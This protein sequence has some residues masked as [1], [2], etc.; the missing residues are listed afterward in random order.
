MNNSVLT[1]VIAT[2]NRNQWIERIT[3]YYSNIR[4]SHKIF[5][6][7]S[8]DENKYTTNKQIVS[9]HSKEL[10]MTH[11]YL[12]NTSNNLAIA[13]IIDQIETEYTIVTGDDDYLVP[14]TLTHCIEFLEKNNDYV[15]VAGKVFSPYVYSTSDST[16]GVE[17]IIDSTNDVVRTI[18]DDSA[19]QRLI[20][21]FSPWDTS[22][23]S[24]QR[25]SMIKTV[26][27]NLKKLDLESH[28][29]TFD[30]A[31]WAINGMS[32]ILGKQKRLDDLLLVMT[33]HALTGSQRLDTMKTKQISTEGLL[34]IDLMEAIFLL[35]NMWQDLLPSSDNP[36][37]DRQAIIGVLSKF[38]S[39]QVNKDFVQYKNKQVENAR[40]INQEAIR[41]YRNSMS[42]LMKSCS[43]LDESIRK[44]KNKF[45][46]R[47]KLEKI[48]KD[49]KIG[50]K[51]KKHINSEIKLNEIKED[52]NLKEDFMPIYN[53]LT[54]FSPKNKSESYT[55]RPI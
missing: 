13:K 7:D 6:V 14:R 24:L 35:G 23:F 33:R 39:N 17:F 38:Y 45:T 12:P 51:E 20:N 55:L 8:S 47:T 28:P 19:I 49:K 41:K 25:S 48:V 9:N 22:A 4:F 46:T 15:A 26:Y 42:R 3:S 53:S 44:V 40:R 32:K 34:K 10:D 37:K 21:S 30:L 52:Q 43:F 18:D 11:Y 16:L 5:I 1:L 2:K 50:H 36:I 27:Q 31:E 54:N 29:D